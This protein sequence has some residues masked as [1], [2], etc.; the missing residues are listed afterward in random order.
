MARAHG[1]DQRRLAELA[2][3]LS[4]GLALVERERGDVD[5]PDRIRGAGARD[6]DHS[7]AVGVAD[8]Q[9]RPVDLV[10]EAGEVVGVVGQT[11]ERIRRCEHRH[12]GGL[13]V[14]DDGHPEGGVGEAAVDEDDGG[15]VR[16]A[17]HDREA[18][19]P[20]RDSRPWHD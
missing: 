17:V 4:E 15:G 11:A 2:E 1:A 12:V 10:D 8:E 3:D 7:A 16:V 20:L 14:L 18:M 6:G 5:E 9:H 13:Q 19:E